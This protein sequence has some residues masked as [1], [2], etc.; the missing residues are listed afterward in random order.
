M[1]DFN[2]KRIVY[3]FIMCYTFLFPNSYYSANPQHLSFVDDIEH[4]KTYTWG[5]DVYRELL[6]EL[7][8]CNVFLI[9]I[10]EAM[11]VVR[12]EGKPELMYMAG[13]CSHPSLFC[14]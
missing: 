14:H 5:M 1:F 8:L 12:G 2:F 13:L 9:D 10:R 11:V 7:G 4:F 6:R 3:L